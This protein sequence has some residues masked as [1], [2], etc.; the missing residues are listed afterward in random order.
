[1]QYETFFGSSGSL[2]ESFNT[3]IATVSPPKPGSTTGTGGIDSTSDPDRDKS[4]MDE[5]T[6]RIII[7]VCVTIA[8][9]L[10]IAIVVMALIIYYRF[11][12]L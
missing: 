2:K 11:G 6:R 4:V 12:I 9:I 1:M 3:Q 8:G 5:N 10:A 7:I